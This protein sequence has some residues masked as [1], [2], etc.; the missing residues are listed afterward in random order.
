MKTIIHNF[1]VQKYQNIFPLLTKMFIV[2]FIIMVFGDFYSTYI[3]N[4]MKYN[5]TQDTEHI[6]SKSHF[7]GAI[8]Q[9]V[10]RTGC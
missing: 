1:D 9:T 4:Y 3:P 7:V 10:S 8:S 2:T 5:T 6:S